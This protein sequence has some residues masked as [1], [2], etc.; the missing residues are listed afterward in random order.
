MR[1]LVLLILLTLQ[2][3]IIF[4]QI[5]GRVLDNDSDQPLT[6]AQVRLTASGFG[7]LTNQTGSFILPASVG[8]NDTLRISYLGYEVLKV[9]VKQ[10]PRGGDLEFRLQVREVSL[11][12]VTI[13]PTDPLDLIRACADEW[14]YNH[15]YGPTNLQAFFRELINQDGKYT[16]LNEAVPYYYVSGEKEAT[17][18]VKLLRARSLRDSSAIKNVNF[19]LG[20]G[21]VIKQISESPFQDMPAE[22][23]MLEEN[24]KQYDYRIDTIIYLD[25]RPTY[26]IEIDQKKHLRKKLYRATL[27]LDVK[28]N[29]MAGLEYGFSPKGKAFRVGQLGFKASAALTL[30]R[31]FGLDLEV[32]SHTG[33]YQFT[34]QDGK[35][36]PVFFQEGMSIWVK[37][38]KMMDGGQEVVTTYAREMVVTRVVP[39]KGTPIPDGE[40]YKKEQSFENASGAYED[41]YW[42]DF[43]YL[44]PGESLRKIAKGIGQ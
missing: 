40:Q 31:T 18:Q 38:P 4:S 24:F 5:E 3:G 34:Y 9:A 35:W 23:F 22:N 36:L 12:E 25:G 44:K 37:T 29:G 28:S 30:A 16:Q 11:A 27:Y 15:R 2:S 26:V 13:R 43:P 14:E 32:R 39:G 6:Y 17:A 33:R 21:G 20:E 10:L 41:S 19:S 1:I 8:N 7:T 42:A